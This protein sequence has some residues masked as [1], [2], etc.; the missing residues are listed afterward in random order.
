MTKLIP[1]RGVWMEFETRKSD[2]I[3]IKFNR[4]RTLPVTILLRALAAVDDLTGNNILGDGSDD[5]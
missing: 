4:K 2:Y 5:E 1:D 3:T